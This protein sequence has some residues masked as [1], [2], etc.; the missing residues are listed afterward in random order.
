[1]DVLEKI[2]TGYYDNKM[3]YKGRNAFTSICQCG[4]P[5]CKTIIFDKNASNDYRKKL[6]NHNNVLIENFKK[7]LLEEFGLSN[8]P[9]KDIIF[10]K[11]WADGH[12][13]GFLEVYGEMDDLVELL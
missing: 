11:V 5:N 9:K 12:A 8:H 3:E 13:N 7:D 4:C 10:N 2:K 6:R 1:M